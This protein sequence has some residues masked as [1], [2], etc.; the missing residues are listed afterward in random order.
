MGKR[1]EESA[2]LQSRRGVGRCHLLQLTASEHFRLLVQLFNESL[3]VLGCV[4]TL[5]LSHELWAVP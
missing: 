2:H 5:G 1:G 4:Q 3:L